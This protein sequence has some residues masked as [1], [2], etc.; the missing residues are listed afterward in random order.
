MTPVQLVLTTVVLHAS[1][2]MIAISNL[3]KCPQFD[4]TN[5]RNTH[6][7]FLHWFRF[8]PNARFQPLLKTFVIQ[9]CLKITEK[10]LNFMKNA[11]YVLSWEHEK[12]WNMGKSSN[13]GLGIHRKVVEFFYQTHD[14][15]YISTW[16]KRLSV[17][18]LCP[19][20]W[21]CKLSQWQLAV[22]PVPVGKYH[23]Y[24]TWYII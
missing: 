7:F 20:W 8:Y 9:I 19:H 5:I 15:S 12:H 23:I 18:Q 6:V 16:G 13:F 24:V 4:Q 2:C 1:I 17:W 11:W 10:L 22:P 14:W 21:N 3:M